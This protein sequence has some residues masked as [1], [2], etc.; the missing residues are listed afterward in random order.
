MYTKTDGV[1]ARIQAQK[2]VLR[3][4]TS[5]QKS[6]AIPVTGLGSPLGYEKSR[7]PHFL[8][9]LP[10][11]GGVVVCLK[12]RLPPPPPRKIPDTRVLVAELTPQG[13][14]AAR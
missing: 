11:G 7:L 3:M 2:C 1:I 14:S 13:H 10:T 12:H 9:N 5:K 8:V 4:R 6:K